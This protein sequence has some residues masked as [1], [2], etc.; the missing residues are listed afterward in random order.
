MT[1]INASSMFSNF[2]NGGAPLD[3][4]E[5][6]AALGVKLD[7]TKCLNFGYMVATS[8]IS[9]LG[10]IDTRGA[11]STSGVNNI[12]RSAA[13]LVTIDKLIVNE[14]FPVGTGSFVGCSKLADITIEG[15]I[16]GDFVI[17]QSPL[18]NNS[19]KSILI[20]LKDFSGTEKAGIN[21]V[22]FSAACWAALDT[23][24]ETSPNGNTWKEYVADLGWKW[25]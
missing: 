7:F 18:T 14:A 22:K 10:V 17:D 9:R 5:H 25:A 16:T 3:M 21:K 12:F 15:Y 20:H 19:L 2:N 11:N 24:G 1:P 8:N 13:Q 6:L 23:E 4:V